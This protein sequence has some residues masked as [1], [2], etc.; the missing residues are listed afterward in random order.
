MKVI[1]LYGGPGSGKSTTRAG[2]FY[3][4]KLGGY[5]V[6]EATEWIK[7]KVYEGSPYAF[8]DQLYTFAKQNKK[9]RE[10]SGKV[11]WVIT[12]SP[13]LLSHVYGGENSKTFHKLVD[14]EYEKYENI[15]VFIKRVKPYQQFG[16]NET[17]EAAKDKDKEIISLL[18]HHGG[19]DLYVSGDELAP[20][21]ILSFLRGMSRND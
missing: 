21:V 5:K 11:D 14:E 8:N 15:N 17:E 4:M 6:E 12:D 7:E 3:L 2:L 19:I 9:L 20:G 1:N 10:M 13:L 16:R 18:E